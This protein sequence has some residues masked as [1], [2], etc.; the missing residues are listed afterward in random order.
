MVRKN[1]KS[2]AINTLSL[3]GLFVAALVGFWFVA[4]GPGE[5]SNCLNS[6]HWVTAY[7]N[8]QVNHTHIFCGELNRRGRLVGFHSRPQGKNP[9]TVRRFNITQTVNSKGIYAGEWIY[10]GSSEETKFST[11]FPDSCTPEQVIN[12]ISH[13]AT[14]TISCPS[15]APSWAWCGYNRPDGVTQD[16][17]FCQ[18]NDG[19]TYTI[20]GATNSDGGINTGFPLR[21]S[22]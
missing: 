18:A 2:T 20:A 13:A 12:S 22:R 16:S 14:N 21:Q 8:R 6:P 1:K 3:L 17:L 4:Y 7:N 11:M 5:A 15:G 10:A 9:S 19:T